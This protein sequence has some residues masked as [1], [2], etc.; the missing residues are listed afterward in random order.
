MQ[1]AWKPEHVVAMHVCNENPHLS[2]D[3][4]SSSLQ[5]SL[6]ALSAVE[7]DEFR[8]ATEDEAW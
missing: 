1:E 5:L 3:T 8:L 4:R 7:H 2:V 6:G